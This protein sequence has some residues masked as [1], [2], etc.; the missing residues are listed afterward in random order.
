VHDRPVAMQ[1]RQNA[2][3]DVVTSRQPGIAPI[4]RLCCCIVTRATLTLGAIAG[5]AATAGAMR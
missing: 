2:V 5:F 3:A 1:A 4:L